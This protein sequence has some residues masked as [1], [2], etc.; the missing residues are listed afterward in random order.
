VRV[1]LEARAAAGTVFKWTP[2]EEMTEGVRLQDYKVRAS[3]KPWGSRLSVS[4]L[5]RSFEPGEHEVPS[6][7]IAYLPKGGQ[8]WKEVWTET[9]PFTVESRISG[10]V[11]ELDIK[12]IKGPLRRMPVP[13][14]V[15]LTLLAV[16]AAVLGVY[17]RAKTRRALTSVPA[18]A[19][20]AHEVALRKI[21][22]LLAKDYISRGMEP[23]FYYELSLIV[24]E[25]L[26]DRFGIRAPEMTTEEFLEHLRFGAALAPEHKDLL[27]DFLTHCDLVKFAR[28]EPGGPEIDAAVASARRVIEETKVRQRSDL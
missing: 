11:L 9:L 26:E 1:R 4:L 5:L 6:L 25:Y 19:P 12:K 15:L 8:E 16:A 20:P 10:D 28:Y 24:R 17:L 22:E 3:Q 7:A 23:Q 21:E 2:P 27:K 14:L 18:P 13:A